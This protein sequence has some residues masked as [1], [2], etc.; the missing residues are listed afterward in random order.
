MSDPF[1]ALMDKS[2]KAHKAGDLKTAQEGYQALLNRKPYDPV[3]LYLLGNLHLQLQYN[4]AGVTYLEASIRA[5]GEQ[6]NPSK[7]VQTVLGG[8][9]NDLGCALKAEHFDDAATKAWEKCI[10]VGGENVGVINNLATLYADSGYPD[11]A[12]PLVEKALGM[13][14]G[15]ENPH[16]H[17]NYALALLSKGEWSRGWEEHEW[18]YKVVSKH[19][20]PRDYAPVWNGE[21]E[22]VLML[23]G[24]QGLGDEIMFATCIP[25]LRAEFPN[26]QLVFE[27][28]PRL[29]GLFSR[30]FG[31]PAYGKA[32]EVKAAGVHIDYQLGLGSLA[33][34][35]R[36]ADA[37]FPSAARAIFH[38][39][40]QLVDEVRAL[41]APF[42]RPWIGYSWMGGTKTTRVHHRSL[43]AKAMKGIHPTGTAFS[44]QYGEYADAEGDAAGLLRL[45]EWTNG[46]N[47]DK[48]AAMV[49]CMD[50]IVTVCT[51]L[52]HLAG[53]LGRSA[54]V[55]TPLRS[56]W[57]YG[58][59][60]GLGAMPWYPQHTL[61]RQLTEGDWGPVIDDVKHDLEQAHADHQS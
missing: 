32:E 35:Y 33:R 59:K 19:V 13:P 2:Y 10:E 15:A 9:W 42:P 20:G 25:D 61:Y 29:R 16:V 40:P 57:R 21:P 55:M 31:Y 38:P 49:W 43:S 45:G 11:K 51:T 26:L 39:D 54:R 48:L 5:V 56:S 17:W 6:E 60:S 46:K 53:A 14:D 47:L 41:L 50:D 18:R 58:L 22:G 27:V 30:G 8:A 12:I 37:A 1:E 23:H 52:V 7:D 4:G 24:E 3:L 28:E 36:T 34:R 44:L